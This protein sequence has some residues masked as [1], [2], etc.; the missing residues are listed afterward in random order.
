MKGLYV[1]NEEYFYSSETNTLINSELKGHYEN[2]INDRQVKISDVEISEPVI[3]SKVK[4]IKQ[5][6]LEITRAC[7]N[8]CKYCIYNNN[9]YSDQ[10]LKSN[11]SM[12]FDTAKKTLDYLKTLFGD[13]K[14]DGLMVCF[15]GGEPLLKFDLMREIIEYS[16]KLFNGWNL[17]YSI[18]TNGSLI[19]EEIATFLI[20]NSFLT[21]ISLDGP[22]ENHN[23]KRIFSNG[24]GTFST[25]IKNLELIKAM[26]AGY[27][28][29]NI[30]LL[31]SFS[32]DLPFDNMIDFF[33]NN[34]LVNQISHSFGYISESDTIYYERYPYDKKTFNETVKR[35]YDE[36]LEKKRKNISLYSSEVN[37]IASLDGLKK[38]LTFRAATCTGKTCSFDSRLFVTANGQFHVCEKINHQNSI[39]DSESGF[40]Y[41]GMVSMMKDYSQLIKKECAECDLFFLCSQCFIHVARK[42]HFEIDEDYCQKFRQEVV[43]MLE[44]Y[45][46][47]HE[48]L[49]PRDSSEDKKTYKF[50]QFIMI[51]KGPVN[52]A[53]INLLSGDVY[54]VSKD[55]LEKFEEKR[56][57]LIPDFIDFF[58][59]ENAFIYVD[60]DRWIPLQDYKSISQNKTKSF[61]L[62]MEDGADIDGIM[63]LF[64]ELPHVNIQSIHYY[65]E[66]VPELDSLA[67]NVLKKEKDFSACQKRC[68]VNKNFKKIGETFYQKNMNYNSCWGGK[69]AVLK[70]GTVKPCIHSEIGIGNLYHSDL[71]EILLKVSEYQEI[72]KDKVEKCKDCELRYTC[73]DCR[74]LSYR[75][76]GSLLSSNPFCIYDPYS[77]TWSES[78]D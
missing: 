66:Q 50:H 18:T 51:V 77:G 9:V 22:E 70:D 28:E 45:V 60:E 64:S 68:T 52:A 65:G 43:A 41:P 46:K 30:S 76:S 15:Y 59:G 19:T 24:K 54:H 3:R 57:D 75:Q 63:K 32:K 8:D 17:S 10:R 26:N 16:S 7:N 31:T 23:E 48:Q 71:S 73:F 13:R 67:C 4:N 33:R 6:I 56:F 25:V 34:E 47:L 53:I 42:G 2:Y 35:V 69:L 36:V 62:E 14:K 12:N 20:E 39:G 38:K 21:Y 1:K 78:H 61:I 40:D 5:V 74:E 29:Q 27:Y 11:D 55:Y 44:D 72:T 58:K 49:T 37:L